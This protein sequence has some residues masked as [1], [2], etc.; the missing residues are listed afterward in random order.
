M[1]QNNKISIGKILDQSF[2]LFFH[3]MHWLIGIGILF[4]LPVLIPHLYEKL[5]GAEDLLPKGY[6]TLLRFVNGSFGLLFTGMMVLACRDWHIT[7]QVSWKALFSEAGK[8]WT[9]LLG[10]SILSSLALGLGFICL[11]IPGFIAL[12]SFSCTFGALLIERCGVRDSF[13]RSS[14]LTKG[15]RILILGLWALMGITYMIVITL[16]AVCSVYLFS[17][18]FEGKIENAIFEALAHPLYA[19]IVFP[20]TFLYYELREKKEGLDLEV[21]NAQVEPVVPAISA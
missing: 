20:S 19:L 18:D 14:K 3:Q 4:T 9:R 11:I 16:I 12:A 21:L 13:V 6:Y 15:N 10:A 17:I 5:T 7:K 8:Q 1:S 2:T